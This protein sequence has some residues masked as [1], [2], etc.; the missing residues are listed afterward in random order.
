MAYIYKITNDINGKIY[1]GKTYNSIEKRF[2]EH[3]KDRLK[4]KCEQ[5]PLYSAMN[6]YGVEH[7]HIELLEETDNPEEREKYWIEYYGSFKNGYN[8]TTGGDGKPYVD[9]DV[10]I[11]LWKDGKTIIEI[12]NLTNYDNGTI[13][14]YLENNGI[15]KKERTFRKNEKT[16]KPVAMLDKETEEII[17]V[18]ATSTDAE[19]FLQKT[20][21][22]Q[23]I[24]EVC[25]GKRK[26]AY[27]YKW[28]YI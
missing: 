6:K 27:G 10:I 13:R 1:I 8:A 20:R 12:H 17:K 26:S 9:K 4:R 24:S 2:K 19:K 7:F 28:K 15:T 22:H 11:S 16:R 3:C 21:S 14:K 18:F 5:R 23:H 25:K